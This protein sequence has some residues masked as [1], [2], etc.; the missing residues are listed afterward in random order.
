M[1][2]TE[3]YLDASYVLVEEGNDKTRDGFTNAW[4]TLLFA[5]DEGRQSGTENTR[6]QILIDPALPTDSE[7]KRSKYQFG[8]KGGMGTAWYKTENWKDLSAAGMEILRVIA[9]H[10]WDVKT[11]RVNVSYQKARKAP[12]RIITNK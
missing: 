9:T 8:K 6:I 10:G 4:E 2:G 7:V 3:T 12:R 5:I 11:V 1:G